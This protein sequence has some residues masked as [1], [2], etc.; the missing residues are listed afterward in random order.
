MAIL[1]LN[2]LNQAQMAVNTL[3]RNRIKA[4]IQRFPK[5]CD[6]YVCMFAIAASAKSPASPLSCP[7]FRVSRAIC[8]LVSQEADAS[9][10]LPTGNS[11]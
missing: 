8:P 2:R 4:I 7:A 11:G 6:P 5:I 3:S 10:K 9:L 1:C